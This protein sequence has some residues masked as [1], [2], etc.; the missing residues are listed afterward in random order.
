MDPHS[1]SHVEI[2]HLTI[3]YLNA[4]AKKIDFVSLLE[5][6][7]NFASFIRDFVSLG[8]VNRI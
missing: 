6:M 2:G 7:L 5:L 1:Y 8:I 4:L 3:F